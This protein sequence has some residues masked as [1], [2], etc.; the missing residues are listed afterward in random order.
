MVDLVQTAFHDGRLYEEV[1][2]QAVVLI[3]KGGRYIQGIGLMELLWNIVTALHD[4]L[5]FF[6]DGCGMGNASLESNMIQQIMSMR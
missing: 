1:M 3:P 6:R 2:W 5:H 4:M